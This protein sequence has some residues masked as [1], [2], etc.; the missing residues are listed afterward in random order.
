MARALDARVCHH[1]VVSRMDSATAFGITV[2]LNVKRQRGLGPSCGHHLRFLQ[3]VLFFLVLHAIS[4]SAAD[5]YAVIITGASGGDVYAQ[6]YDRW[7]VSLAAIIKGKFSYSDDRLFV[8]AETEHEGIAKATREN[9]TK[10]FGSLRNRLKN[11]DLL[12]IILFGHGTTADDG[13]GKFNLVGPDLSSSE[14]AELLRP[15]S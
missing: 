13:E 1:P 6:K 4:V 8:L 9:V 10:L 2:M 11:D 7:R 3:G 14:W 15:I 5:R 12:I